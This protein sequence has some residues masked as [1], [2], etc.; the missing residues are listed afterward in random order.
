MMGAQLSR[1]RARAADWNAEQTVHGKFEEIAARYSERA[2]LVCPDGCWTYRQLNARANR[3]ARSIDGLGVAPGSRIAVCLDRSPDLIACLIAILKS[4]CAYV[5]VDTTYPPE[6][7]A[8]LLRDIDAPMVFADT[9]SARH[10]DLTAAKVFLLDAGASFLAE[11]KTE[12]VSLPTTS[13]DVCYVMYTSGTTGVPKGVIVPHRGVTRLVCGADY[14]TFSPAEVFLQLSPVSFDASTFEIWGSLL[15]G[16]CLALPR[17]G[18]LS[19][20]EIGRA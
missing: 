11:Q 18:V 20:E 8:L 7:V 15:N 17:P 16:G 1:E 12:N 2:A 10:L 19:L 3:I 14:A 6:R 9:A 5:P 13:N 4:G